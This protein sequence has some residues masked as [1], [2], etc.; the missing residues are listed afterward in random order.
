MTYRDRTDYLL[1]QS[2]ICSRKFVTLFH[3]PHN[4]YLPSNCLPVVSTHNTRMSTWHGAT[5]QPHCSRINERYTT[6]LC[7][8]R[9]AIRDRTC[10]CRS[11][12]QRKSR[13]FTALRQATCESA[14]LCAISVTFSAITLGIV[15]ADL[16]NPHQC[17]T[18]RSHLHEH[19]HA[20]AQL[21]LPTI[22]L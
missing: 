18:H 5:R 14:E 6:T 16:C 2:N 15:C 3:I 13:V 4:R 9:R 10:A 12:R 21:K 17:S 22:I 11:R 7:T 1:K 19:A 8:R 20:L